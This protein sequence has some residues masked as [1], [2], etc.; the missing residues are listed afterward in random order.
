MSC[1]PHFRLGQEIIVATPLC[2]QSLAHVKQNH[3]N[4]FPGTDQQRPETHPSKINSRGVICHSC[5]DPLDFSR[6]ILQFRRWR[7]RDGRLLEEKPRI[8]RSCPVP[9]DA[10][11]PFSALPGTN[12]AG[13]G[14]WGE[15]SNQAGL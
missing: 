5:H 4:L 7:I 6:A 1:L 12:A 2:Y 10:Y 11:R 14:S 3:G 13:D 8:L 15:G 9:P